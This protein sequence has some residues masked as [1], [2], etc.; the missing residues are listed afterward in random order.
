MLLL[1]PTALRLLP[2][3][4]GGGGEGR[5]APRPSLPVR[6]HGELYDLAAFEH[7]GGH[8]VLRRTAGT[9]GGDITHLF[10][11]N[12]REPRVSA[13]RHFRI[14]ESAP[15]VDAG[16][17]PTSEPHSALY[18]ELKSEVYAHLEARGVD[19][20]H[21]FRW[22][23]YAHRLVCLACAHAAVVHAAGDGSSYTAIGVGSAAAYGLLTGR[24]TWTHAHNGVHNPSALPPAMRAL[25]AVDFVGVVEAWMAEHHAHH[26][27][28]NGARDPDASWFR[29]LF[30]YRD[31]AAGG[32]SLRVTALAAAAYPFLVPVMLVKSL[33]HARASDPDGAS[34]LAWVIAVAPLRFAIDFAILG[35][36][37]FAAALT[38]ATAYICG[39]FVATH[40]APHNHEPTTG[41]WAIDQMRS[42]ND[43]WPECRLWS[44][45]TGGIS[46][47]TEHHLFPHFS[48]EALP[49]VA[50][51]VTKFASRHGLPRHTFSPAGLLSEHAALLSGAGAAGHGPAQPPA[52]S[53]A[54][55]MVRDSKRGPARAEC[56]SEPGDPSGC[57]VTSAKDALARLRGGSG[58]VRQAARAGN[59]T[60]ILSALDHTALVPG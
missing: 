14:A 49:E 23:P 43:V 51:V 46:H 31:V 10:Y 19:W 2:T 26:A 11:S 15:L 53:P 39:T 42:T 29:P 13:L 55:A 22:E 3:S 48:S 1:A 9:K 34:T 16:E 7:P 4:G 17:Q 25:M 59:F 41:D 27:H 21:T 36:V 54:C 12:H 18:R 8:E 20:R 50:T 24:M 45:V 52:H 38:V 6:I 56:A 58:G 5:T 37:G 57:P 47:H 32:G 33:A 44:M 28:T 40:Q 60:H 30:D 35:P